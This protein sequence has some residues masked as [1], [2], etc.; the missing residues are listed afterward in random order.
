MCGILIDTQI[1]GRTMEN[2]SR[3][4]SIKDIMSIWGVLGVGGGQLYQGEVCIFAGMSV[5]RAGPGGASLWSMSKS[6]VIFAGFERKASIPVL[7]HNC[8]VDS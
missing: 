2:T 8:F 1:D 4:E 5:S 3:G 6:S 7:K